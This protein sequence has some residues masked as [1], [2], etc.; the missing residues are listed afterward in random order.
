MKSTFNTKSFSTT[1]QV[2]RSWTG[3]PYVGGAALKG[4]GCDCVGLI[5]GVMAE[6]TGQM[7]PTPPGWR[8]DWSGSR[9]RPLI[10]AARV[11]LTEIDPADMTGGDVV[12]FRLASGREAHAGILSDTTHVI[13]AA[14]GLGVVEVPLA[15]WRDQIV[16]AG[17]IT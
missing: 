7:P 16:F 12:A 17:R 3:T 14:E 10:A 1:V 4:K 11:F 13:H 15:A 6:V 5:R 9:A 2:A 8:A